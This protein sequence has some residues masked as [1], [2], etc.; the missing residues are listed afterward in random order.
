MKVDRMLGIITLLLQRGRLTA[1]ELAQHFGVST[2]TIYRDVEAISLAGV[3]VYASKGASGG[4][5]LA[6]GYTLSRLPVNDSERE[7]LLL[8]LQTLGATRYPGVESMLAKLSA[9][10]K[11]SSAW[12]SVDFAP[13]GSTESERQ[14]FQLIRS[15][16]L[17]RQV[18]AFDYLDAACQR[19]SRQA[20]PVHLSFIGHTW[21]LH[22]WCRQRQA[23]RVFKVTRMRQL[24]L[25]AETF[26]PR[27]LRLFSQPPSNDAAGK[28][29]VDCQ[30]LF[31]PRVEY[32]LLD[33]FDE[34]LIR[35]QA[36]GRLRVDVSFP[37]D[38]WVYGT[39]L[40]F[41][42]DLQVLGPPHLRAIVQQRLQQALAHYQG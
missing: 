16:I 5:N 1:G 21:Y 39:L 23:A 40:S 35:P 6:D 36:D 17:Q 3:P 11:D 8:A 24:R 32:R 42:G 7:S 20:E 33:L 19:T 31:D 12:V 37:E 30:L 41:G 13:W 22:A 38:E 25:T 26:A 9:L 10:F 34:R 27:D 14:S 4:I 28:G 18:L 2:R 29:L 15:A